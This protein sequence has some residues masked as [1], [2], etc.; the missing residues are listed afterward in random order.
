M[1]VFVN[2]TNHIKKDE[3]KWILPESVTK[4]LDE[5]MADEV[6]FLVEDQKGVSGLV[7]EY[8]HIGKY[9]KVTVCVAATPIMM[10][11]NSAFVAFTGYPLRSSKVSRTS[12]PMRLLPSRNA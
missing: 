4:Y 9:K 8:L 11:A 6:E 1:K 10:S 2:G 5:L 3:G 7:Q 12:A